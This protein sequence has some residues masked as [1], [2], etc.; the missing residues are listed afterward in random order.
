MLFVPGITVDQRQITQIKR[1]GVL[2]LYS[3]EEM[4]ADTACHKEVTESTAHLHNYLGSRAL[5][6][7]DSC[8]L[9]RV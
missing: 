3:K 4:L 7:G 9:E 8:P 1:I 6:L 2:Y 5:F